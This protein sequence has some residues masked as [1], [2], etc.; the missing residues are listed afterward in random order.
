MASKTAKP[1]KKQTTFNAIDVQKWQRDANHVAHYLWLIFN[2]VLGEMARGGKHLDDA[3][4]FYNVNE[5][6]PTDEVKHIIVQHL[7]SRGF[8]ITEQPDFGP[9]GRKPWH[10]SWQ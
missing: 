9:H 2:R 6:Q 5:E 1:A 3:F 4:H 10:I 7:R 8:E